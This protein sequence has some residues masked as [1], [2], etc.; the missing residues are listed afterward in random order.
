MSRRARRGALLL[1]DVCRTGQT[2]LLD[3][4]VDHVTGI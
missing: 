3:H 4:Y 1:T 2:P